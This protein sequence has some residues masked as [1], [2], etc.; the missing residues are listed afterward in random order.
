MKPLES[1]WEPNSKIQY[2]IIRK[3][4]WIILNVV[5]YT[6]FVFTYDE[7]WWAQNLTLF[8]IQ[9]FFLS[10]DPYINYI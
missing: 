9:L 3:D 6:S 2:S 5:D 1:E 7:S 8:N 4:L 10:D